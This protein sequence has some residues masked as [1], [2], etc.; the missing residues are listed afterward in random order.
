MGVN[1]VES[2]IGLSD[3]VPNSEYDIRGDSG[4]ANRRTAN[5]WPAA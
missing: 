5:L 3:D 1:L 4:S 2:D